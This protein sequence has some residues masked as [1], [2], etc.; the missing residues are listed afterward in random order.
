MNFLGI[1]IER[2]SSFPT[3]LGFLKVHSE[4]CSDKAFSY[5]EVLFIYFEIEF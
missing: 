5:V 3:C 2:I 4:N 1:L